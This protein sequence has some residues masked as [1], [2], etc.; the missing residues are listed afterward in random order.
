MLVLPV[1]YME[2]ALS[3]ARLSTGYSSPNPAVGA[4]VAKEGFIIGMGYTQP[5]GGAHA[6]IMALC[7]A[8]EAARK[9]TMYVTLEPC[10]HY[11][12]TPPCTRAIIEAGISEVHI[13]MLDPNPLMSGQGVKQ[14]NDAHIKTYVGER[15]QEAYKIN[16]AYVK[17][18]TT[19]QPFVIA[20]FAA[21]LDG[22]IAT[23]TGDSKWIT[24]SYARR[25]AHMLRSSVDA[26]VVGVDT[27][28]ADNPRLTSRSCGG[29]G[30]LRKEQPL[31]IVIDSHGRV[32]LDSRIFS[33]PGNTLLAVSESL[34]EA[35]RERLA[36]VGAEIVELPG[37]ER[38][39]DL[40]KL[41]Q[42][43]GKR[44]IVSVLVEGGGKLLGSLFDQRLV[45]KVM[46]FIAPIIIGGNEART[47]VCGRGID[48]IVEAEHLKE[49]SVSQFGDNVLISGYT[50]SRG[51]L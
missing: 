16:E 11:G 36:Q 24:S 29:R 27:V 39:V 6:E 23:K 19:G 14:L 7:Q 3:L 20:K 31:R 25:C 51:T 9:A 47:A 45:D 18:I 46:A 15:K 13:A 1:D 35:R 50:T 8:G 40:G 42:M 32:P 10:C 30:G 48:R 4:I 2:C 38:L 5:A 17:Y 21:S 22:K 26:I 34:E 28:I 33:S 41:F 49:V 12:R 44:K 43:L 37:E